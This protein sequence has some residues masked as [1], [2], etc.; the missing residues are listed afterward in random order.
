MQLRPV[1]AEFTFSWLIHDTWS[2]AYVGVRRLAYEILPSS[3]GSATAEDGALC[4]LALIGANHL[5]EVGL[6]KALLPFAKAIGK[7]APLTEGLLNEATYHHMLARWLPL[8]CGKQV[9]LGG[10]PFASTERLRRRPND[11]AHKSSALATVEMAKSALF[12]AVE[13][14]RAVY[15][16]SATPFPYEAVFK[17]Y[18]LLDEPWFSQI[19]FPGET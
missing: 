15:A 2:E 4:Q 12:S 18:P 14:T 17:Q 6:Y 9:D 10:E 7:A 11:T 5:M 8:A 13:G 19:T 1:T 16:F 3:Q